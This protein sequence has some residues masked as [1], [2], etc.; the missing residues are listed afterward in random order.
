MEWSA[1]F[2]T[3]G[4]LV[5]ILGTGDVGDEGFCGYFK[6]LLSHPDWHPG[7]PVLCDFRG[8]NIGK[9]TKED[10]K[11][12]VEIDQ[13]SSELTKETPSPIAVVVAKELDYG[14]VRMWELYANDMYPSHNVFLGVKDAKK[15]LRAS[16]QWRTEGN[17]NG[18]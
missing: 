12:L 1:E 17:E 7:M 15:W 2:E 9:L 14:L 13:E 11:H 18:V 10:I 16:G 5:T 3:D 6:A 8:M 4:Y